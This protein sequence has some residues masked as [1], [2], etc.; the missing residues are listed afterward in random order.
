MI[1]VK[2]VRSKVSTKLDLM[3]TASEVPMKPPPKCER[4]IRKRK[5]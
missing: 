1:V 2:R 5:G 3:T 4:K